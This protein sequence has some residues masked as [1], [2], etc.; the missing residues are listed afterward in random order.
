MWQTVITSYMIGQ[1]QKQIWSLR[2][3]A[4]SPTKQMEEQV[5]ED[6]SWLRTKPGYVQTNS[7]ESFET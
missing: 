3:R 4:L 7:M 1:S 5:T 6:H 2:E